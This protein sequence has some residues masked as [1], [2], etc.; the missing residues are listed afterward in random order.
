LGNHNLNSGQS[1]TVTA[2]VLKPAE[3]N[4]HVRDLFQRSG[5]EMMTVFIGC[6]ICKT[7]IPPGK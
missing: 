3:T 7:V 2:K 6:F 5:A 4:Y 1:R